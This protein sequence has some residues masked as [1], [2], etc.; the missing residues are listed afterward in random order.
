MTTS[1]IWCIATLGTGVDDDGDGFLW[2]ASRAL[3]PSSGTG[4]LTAVRDGKE[5]S[6]DWK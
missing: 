5:T 4:G 3:G 2:F 6:R 1:K